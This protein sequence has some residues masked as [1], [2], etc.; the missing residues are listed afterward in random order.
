MQTGQIDG[1]HGDPDYVDA[2]S[3][4]MP[5]TGGLGSGSTAS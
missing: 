2:L 3:Y 1:E 4:G 5:P